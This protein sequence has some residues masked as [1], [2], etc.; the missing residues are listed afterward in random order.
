VDFELSDEQ[1][2]LRAATRD[3]LAAH[4]P[5]TA[6][7][8]RAERGDD[9]APH[10]WRLGCD[11]GWTGVML[12]EEHGGAAQG[13][14]ELVLVAEEFGRAAAPGPFLPT[15]IVGSALAR[16]GQVELQARI[17]P[18]LAAGTAAATWAF[19]EPGAPWTLDG[20]RATARRAAPD[21]TVVLDGV[22]T[23]VQDAASATWILVTARLDGAPTSFLV[24]RD[25][26]GVTIRRQ[27]VLDP[28]RSFYEVTLDHVVVAADRELLDGPGTQRL[29]HDAAVAN[30]ADTLG[31]ID[32]MLE[33]TVEHVGTRVQFGRPIGTFQAVKHKCATM[34]LLVHATRA[35]THYAAM[36]ADAGASDAAR[37]ACAAAAH[38]GTAAQDVAGEALQL[39]GGIGFSWE[40]DLHLFL[41]RATVDSMLHGGPAVHHDQLCELLLA[42]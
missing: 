3:L 7:R 5:I 29:L 1:A 36:A 9:I 26:A 2:M 8:S 34:A 27:E 12:P 13:L 24:D 37:A 30:A 4:C 22:K 20:V 16:S 21:R 42:P 17:L 10:L 15:A 11:L 19:A 6:V 40:H 39:H 28:T 33:L 25:S 18:A 38:A 31:A 14:V 41:R 23:A 35:A 32:R